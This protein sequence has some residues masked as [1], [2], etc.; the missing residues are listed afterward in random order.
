M[1]SPTLE[2]QNQI[3]PRSPL[4]RS[5]DRGFVWLTLLFALGV[6]GV[7]IWMVIEVAIQA[8]PAM[9]QFGAGFLVST[10]WDPNTDKYG[11]LPQIYGTIVTSAIALI[12]AVPV[13]I[14]VAVFLSENYIA[15]QIRL[16]IVFLVELLA[17][18]PSVVYGF[19]GVIVLIPILL[20]FQQW[21]HQILGWLPIFST[22][23]SGPGL[24]PAGV[25][26]AIMVLPTITV[27]SRD[28]LIALP[29]ELRQ[30]AVGLGATRWETIL[31]VLLP[32]AFSGIIG[33]V[34]L[35][36]GR[37]IGETMA[38]TLVIGNANRIG[39]SILAPGNTIPSLL[40]SE[41]PEASALQK[42]ALLYAALILFGITLIVNIL[43]QLLVRRVQRI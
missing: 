24:V 16:I 22:Q 18:I 35:A 9:K 20:V 21:L 17:A 42:A 13:G 31:K 32:A 41:F 19:W 38:V 27:I 29:S 8:I 4:S 40:A 33:G 23:P 37:A 25:V 12:L 1:N 6:A 34:M 10:V 30:A 28:A 5:I 2:T 11:V 36:L 14:G 26:L 43:A 7:L 39:A 3:Q 15:P